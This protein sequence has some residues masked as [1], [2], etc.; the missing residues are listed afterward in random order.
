MFRW[1]KRSG[2]GIVA[3][4]LSTGIIRLRVNIFKQLLTFMDSCG[5]RS[6]DM[7][8]KNKNITISPTAMYWNHI[9]DEITENFK[10]L[11]I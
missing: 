10:K 5:N 9:S 8:M 2:T 3:I 4:P 11:G 7:G 6:V 1:L